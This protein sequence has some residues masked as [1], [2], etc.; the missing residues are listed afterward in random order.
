MR[1]DDPRFE[2]RLHARA[3]GPDAPGSPRPGLSGPLATAPNAADVGF[4]P[5]PANLAPTRRASGV[6]PAKGAEDYL[7]GSRFD[8]DFGPW[9]FD[10]AAF[11][12]HVDGP[13]RKDELPLGLESFRLG[14]VPGASV[15]VRNVVS[16]AVQPWWNDTLN[17]LAWAGGLSDG[18]GH[19]Q[20]EGEVSE[21]P[22]TAPLALTDS[23]HV[24]VSI[25]TNVPCLGGDS[26]GGCGLGPMAVYHT[27]LISLPITLTFA[28]V[29]DLPSVQPVQCGPY[30]MNIVVQTE[31]TDPF[32]APGEKTGQIYHVVNVQAGNPTWGMNEVWLSDDLPRVLPR[33]AS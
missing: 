20:W 28:P 9:R 22:D 17:N 2:S 13:H 25:E 16:A 19:H 31:P 12:A 1:N 6:L 32:P 3:E 8:I 23:C 29:R 18:Q 7:V 10:L 33:S 5:E 30:L 24:Q 14:V 27:F 4:R 15:R 21:G 26:D 11:G